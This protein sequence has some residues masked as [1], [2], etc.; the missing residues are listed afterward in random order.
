ML[1]Q[2]LLQLSLSEHVVVSLVNHWL[3]LHV[4]L[5]TLHVNVLQV[6]LVLEVQ[7]PWHEHVLLCELFLAYA[8]VTLEVL[9]ER[10][11]VNQPHAAHFQDSRHLVDCSVTDILCW[12]V[13]DHCDRNEPIA[14]AR[15]HWQVQTIGAEQLVVLVFFH[16]SLDQP[17]APVSADHKQIR[18][19]THVLA[20]TASNIEHN[21][22][23]M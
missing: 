22:A 14:Y 11:Y 8:L 12:K 4:N 15:P 20:I 6:F 16:C 5:A 7:V 9:L 18:I 19:D 2:V 10:P 1:L 13:V 3:L 23:I 17:H 21:I